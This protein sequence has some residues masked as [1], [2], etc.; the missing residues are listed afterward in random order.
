MKFYET[1]VNCETL[2]FKKK[3]KKII[4]C[5]GNIIHKLIYRTKEKN[6]KYFN[7]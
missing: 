6:T 5:D 4:L 3:K 2:K 7:K 1:N